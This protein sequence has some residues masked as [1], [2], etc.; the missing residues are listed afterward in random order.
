MELIRFYIG[1]KFTTLQYHCA[2]ERA[3]IGRI[4]VVVDAWEKKR[5]LEG[6]GVASPWLDFRPEKT[7][8]KASWEYCTYLQKKHHPYS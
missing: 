4:Q 1:D 8:R 5:Y 2:H 3:H 7:H 6:V